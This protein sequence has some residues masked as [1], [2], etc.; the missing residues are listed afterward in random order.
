MMSDPLS[1]LVVF[2]VAWWLCLFCVLPIGVQ[3]QVEADSVVEGSEPGAPVV[4][5]L[6]K[7]AIWAT[8]GAVVITILAGIYLNFIL[9]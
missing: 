9:V 3:S 2:V 7:K 8:I 1:A 5:G 4:H 6:R